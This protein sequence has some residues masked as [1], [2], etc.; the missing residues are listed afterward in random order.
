[1]SQPATQR[2]PLS[3]AAKI[4]YGL[5]L[6]YVVNV[7]SSLNLITLP[8]MLVQ[9][10]AML[11]RPPVQAQVA[12][13]KIESIEIN[14]SDSDFY[15][16]YDS[17]TY[18][19]EALITYALP[20]GQKYREYSEVNPLSPCSSESKAAV[21]VGQSVPLRQTLV[22]FSVISEE[23]DQMIKW[24]FADFVF[25]VVTIVLGLVV[26]GRLVWRWFH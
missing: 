23:S 2:K 26:L 25:S 24:E 11:T 8:S 17:P 6:I 4:G 3:L 12:H 7:M 14:N 9:V 15:S 20:D 1:M 18:R 19:C 22:G 16:P 5:L 13:I 10:H 21:Q